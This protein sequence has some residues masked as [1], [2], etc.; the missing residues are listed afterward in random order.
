MKN[1]IKIS[2]I[3]RLN[4]NNSVYLRRLVLLFII[5]TSFVCYSLSQ[6]D[7]TSKGMI[8]NNEILKSEKTVDEGQINNDSI[9]VE[10]IEEPGDTTILNL[11]NKIIL[12]IEYKDRMVIDR[13]DLTTG[14]KKRVLDLECK[15]CEPEK[16]PYEFRGHW[17]GVEVGI[18]NFLNNDFSLKRPE[19]YDYLDLK[20]GRSWNV[21]INFAQTSTP[22]IGNKFGIVGGLGLEMNSYFL[23]GDNTIQVN[24]TSGVIEERPL[25]QY[26]IRRNK[27]NTTYLTAPLILEVQFG[28]NKSRERFFISAGA[29]VGLRIASVIKVVHEVDDKKHKFKERRNDLNL[30][31]WRVGLTART[32]YKDIFNFYANYYLTP[33][34]ETDMGPELYP[35]AV[36]VRMNF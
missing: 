22:I 21:N 19:G 29:V 34:F 16:D 8:D 35:F 7:T 26:N 13:I 24:D 10:D 2:K 4:Y 12:F 6:N 33:L 17:S 25:G 30:N 1:N 31:R 9:I 36:G 18:N 27:L 5:L 11:G 15:D 3:K 14:E 20:T 28:E 32:G 23:K